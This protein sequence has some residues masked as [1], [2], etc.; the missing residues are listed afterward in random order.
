MPDYSP[1]LLDQL[2]AAGELVWVGAGALG[3]N[4]GWIVL[5]AGGAAP[6]L[7]PEPVE[8]ELSPLAHAGARR[9][10]PRRRAVLPAALR[11]PRRSR[12]T[13]SC[14][15]ALWELVWAGRV[16][17]RY[18]GPAARRAPR[19]RAVRGAAVPR[20]P[21][22]RAAPAAA[23]R[24]AAT[25][26][27]PPAAAGRW[28]QRPGARDRSDPPRVTPRPSS[29]CAATVSSP[30]ARSL[31][32]RLP[33]GFAGVYPVLTRARGARRA[34]GA[35]TSSKGSAAR[36]SPCPAPSTACARSTPTRRRARAPWS[37][38]ATDPANPFGAA[39]PW[40]ER[41]A[42]EAGHR[43]GRKAGAVVVLV[44]GRLVLYVERGGSTL[45]TYGDD[46]AM[47]APAV[48][49]ARRRGAQ[50]H[51]RPD[52]GR[53]RRRRAG[54]RHAARRGA[55]RGRLQPHLQRPAPAC[56]RATPSTWR[57]APARRARRAAADAHRLPRAAPGHRRSRRPHRRRRRRPRQASAAARRR[58]R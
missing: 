9:A 22:P 13:T 41:G 24:R 1:V 19:R 47:L 18:L 35:V 57:R 21:R 45:L 58:R 31:A 44:G 34:A 33:G 12:R 23:L 52:R 14:V 53:A 3:M 29:C 56:L 2:G 48:D 5:R 36:S 17:Q 16:D 37:L 43:A 49:G 8:V 11:S 27:G 32:D 54:A 6:L 4:D 30:A 10:R 7:L 15:L 39:L 50:R 25:R 20:R 28:S 51:A 40:P 38:A 42:A 46:P 55:G 26:S